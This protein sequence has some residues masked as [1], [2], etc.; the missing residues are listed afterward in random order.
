MRQHFKQTEQ[1]APESRG[2]K[3]RPQAASPQQQG[4]QRSAPQQQV[5]P[6]GQRQQPQHRGDEEVQK[7]ARP[8]PHRSSEPRQHTSRGSSQ[9]RHSIGGNRRPLRAASAP[10]KARNK[11]RVVDKRMADGN[12]GV[13]ARNRS[14]DTI[15]ERGE[16]LTD[17]TAKA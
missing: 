11:I 5:A 10:R 1:K 4:N 15:R 17:G 7:S 6:A 8:R 12:K 13:A 16:A 9:P 3:G 14:A 2:K